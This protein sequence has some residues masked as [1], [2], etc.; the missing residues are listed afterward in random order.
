M[1]S[2]QPSLAII[3]AHQHLWDPNRFS[4]SWMHALPALNRRHLLE[5]YNSAAKGTGITGTVY[6]DTRSC[7]GS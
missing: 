3:D 2:I 5:E 1:D 6:V 7:W 4:Y